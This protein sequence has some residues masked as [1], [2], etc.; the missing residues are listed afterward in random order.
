MMLA[1]LS[2]KICEQSKGFLYY[3][4]DDLNKIPERSSSA[5]EWSRY[6]H[7]N[8]IIF[9]QTGHTAKLVSQQ[10]IVVTP[11]SPGDDDETF[12][13]SHAKLSG[14]S[15]HDKKIKKLSNSLDVESSL[16]TWINQLTSEIS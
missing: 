9:E 1:L 15:K 8:C 11:V 5:K 16:Q 3:I 12:I 10:D 4:S 13:P 2:L 6:Y 7:D 14:A